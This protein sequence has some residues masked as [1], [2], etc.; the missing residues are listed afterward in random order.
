[1]GKKENHDLFCR[2]ITAVALVLVTLGT[3]FY[4]TSLMVALFF[5]LVCVLLAWEWASLM[6]VGKPAAAM[7]SMMMALA[8]W[9]IGFLD[10]GFQTF[11]VFLV[12]LFWIVIVPF[13][14]R[15]T[16]TFGS[17]DFVSY[18]VGMILIVGMWK[19]AFYLYSYH[20]NLFLAT[21]SIAFLSDTGA[22]FAGKKWGKHPLAPSLSPGK[23]WEGFFGGFFLCM[24]AA[25]MIVLWVDY[26][27]S[28]LGFLKLFCLT[29][30]LVVVG[31]WGDLFESLLKRTA[32]VKDSGKILP[33]HGGVFDRMD[34]LMAI[35]PVCA[36][37]F[38]FEEFYLMGLS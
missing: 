33:G 2:V 16:K 34:S 17:N 23:T 1:M 12:G 18:A 7:F 9:Q 27:W 32:Q 22:F 21:A 30:L 11:F 26:Q 4:G 5:G 35:L 15:K 20:L 6:K 29:G 19:S 14:L 10:V 36:C 37:V 31:V 8:C 24:L 28:M 25:M 38:L 3:L 13:L